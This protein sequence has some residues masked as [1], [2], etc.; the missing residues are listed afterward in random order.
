M[1]PKPFYQRN[2]TAL[3]LIAAF[4]IAVVAFGFQKPQSSKS[5][6]PPH[7]VNTDT[8][9]KQ[10]AK[11]PR[12]KK[13]RDLDEALE[14]LEA[15]DITVEMEKAQR[16]IREAIKELDANRI[17]VQAE[18]ALKEI[19]VQKIQKEIQESMAKI[20]WSKMK[21][22][23]ESVQKEQMANLEIE[24]KRME[25]ELKEIGPKLE[26]EMAEMKKIDMGQIE[27]EMERAKKELLEV[28]PKLKIELEHAQKEIERAKAELKEFKTFIDGLDADGVINKKEEYT[29]N[30]ENGVLTIN[31]KK[32]PESVYNKY[33]SFLEKH[34]DFTIKKSADDFNIDID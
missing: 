13:V 17:R 31:G 28:E 15:L 18:V 10:K 22:D 34:K 29:I 3:M 12:E 8:V 26:K 16:E 7:G 2:L 25:K 24:M 5:P 6:A 4:T 14:E 1:K 32:Q 11:E 23:L 27:K 33:R 30:H 9:P 21:K 20:D 19:D